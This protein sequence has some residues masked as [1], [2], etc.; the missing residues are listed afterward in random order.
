M[1][2]C[3]GAS[4]IL[5]TALAA[6][7]LTGAAATPSARASAS[8]INSIFA[9][10]TVSGSAISC[11]AQADGTRVCHGTYNNG[12]GGNDVRLESFD[13]QPLA[14]YVTL[15]PAPASGGD[16]PYPLVIQSH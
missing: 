10:Q 12:P 13:G 5:A 4:A 2:R 6:V 3:R 9:G 1:R 8:P 16:G 7:V 11:S 15:P 14:L